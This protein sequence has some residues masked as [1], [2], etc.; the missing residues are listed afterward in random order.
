MEIPEPNNFTF[1]SMSPLSMELQAAPWPPNYKPRMLP[2]YNG[3]SHPNAFLL[4]YEA[5]V[6][7]FGGDTFA[8]AKS[9]VMALEGTVQR[10]YSSITLR[11]IR[12][13]TQL[14]EAL[15][16]NFQ[17]FQEQTITSQALFNCRQEP[18]ESLQKYFRSFVNLRAQAA[19]KGLQIGP[20]AHAFAL[21]PPQTV[22]ELYAR[23]SKYCRADNDLRL[24]RKSSSSQEMPNDFNR[25]I[26]VQ[27]SAMWDTTSQ[28]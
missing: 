8:L 16:S 7:S 24:D 3:Q 17:G 18:G 23:T 6:G 13:C 14:K 27:P 19:V 25:G 28:L 12:S 10:W 20:C 1:D 22:Q 5:M 21:E 11:S 26:F 2:H 15:L 9:L 4:S